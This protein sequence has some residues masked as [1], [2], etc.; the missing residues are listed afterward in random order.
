MHLTAV[1]DDVGTMLRSWLL[2]RSIPMIAVGTLVAIGLSLMHIPFAA[3]L[4]VFVGILSFIP[5]IGSS[6]PAML[7]ALTIDPK[8]ALLVA[9]IYWLAHFVDDFLVLPVAE[10]RIVS[11]PQALTIAFQ[12]LLAGP[13]GIVGVMLAAPLAATT[14]VVV[15]RLWIVDV[16][17]S[18]PTVV[19]R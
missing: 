12:L 16:A 14:I 5:N 2:A 17:E 6:I 3:T 15:R 9:L 10:R 8:S 13:A 19:V 7:L 1:I 18:D 11:L 4:G